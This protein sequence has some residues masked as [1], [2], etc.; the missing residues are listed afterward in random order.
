MY[1]KSLN[2][3]YR[4]SLKDSSVTYLNEYASFVDSHTIE[5]SVSKL[6]CELLIIIIC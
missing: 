3:G 5:V 2:W 4:V 1:I 6:V